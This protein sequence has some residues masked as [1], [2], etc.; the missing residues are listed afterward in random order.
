MGI[1]L[2]YSNNNTVINN[3]ISKCLGG[4]GLA[5]YSSDNTII[6]NSITNNDGYGI[7]LFQEA[8][9]NTI[10]EN[11]IGSN[12]YHGLD[13]ELSSNNIIY[14][15]NFM[16]NSPNAYDRCNNIWDDGYPSGGNYWDDYN[17]IDYDGD[18]I[19]DTPYPISGGS[20]QDNYP[21]METNGWDNPPPNKPTIN[22]PD[23]GKP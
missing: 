6:N 11:N 1:S 23:C 22:G 18:G 21:F 4:I 2:W 20:N 12:N 17:G 13:L 10:K 15:N 3:Y 14:H 7:K 9:Y 5:Y 19:G 16:N 8:N